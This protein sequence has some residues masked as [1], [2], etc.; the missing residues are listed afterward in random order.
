MGRLLKLKDW[1]EAWSFA[2]DL[3]AKARI[4]DGV[5]VRPKAYSMYDGAKGI[6]IML[7]DSY[8][9]YYTDFYSGITDSLSELKSSIVN[10]VN[11]AANA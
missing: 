11:R 5:D 6:R 3:C 9:N 7:F 4:N 1:N 8:G 2:E 10:C